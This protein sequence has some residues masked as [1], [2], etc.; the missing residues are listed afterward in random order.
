LRTAAE[1][2]DGAI[3][4]KPYIA[5]VYARHRL[6]LETTRLVAKIEHRDGLMNFEAIID[7]ADGIIFS[8]GNLGID[9]PPEKMFIA[10]KMVRPSGCSNLF[11]NES[12]CS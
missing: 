8:R 6:G 12:S 7:A 10:Q 1:D 5:S 3:E 4:M 11:Q 2:A 9:L